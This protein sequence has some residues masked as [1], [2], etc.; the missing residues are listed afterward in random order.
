MQRKAFANILLTVGL[1][2][3]FAYFGTDKFMHPD[4]WID[5]MPTWMEGLMGF[6]RMGWM[7]ITGA[8]EI[9]FAVMLLIPVRVIRQSGAIL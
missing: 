7:Y 4:W 8:L 5:W 3:V 6:S 2:F 9:L 1:A